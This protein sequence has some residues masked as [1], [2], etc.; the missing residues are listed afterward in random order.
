VAPFDDERRNLRDI[1]LK[2]NQAAQ[3]DVD[4]R[5]NHTLSALEFVLCLE[6]VIRRILANNIEIN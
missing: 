6:T 2:T 1:N 4:Q 5:S 3:K